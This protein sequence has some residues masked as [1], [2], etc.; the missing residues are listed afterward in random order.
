MKFKEIVV[1]LSSPEC[2]SDFI[3]RTAEKITEIR[4]ETGGK[5]LEVQ[6][7]HLRGLQE[8]MEA[9]RW[10]FVHDFGKYCSIGAK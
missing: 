7:D 2:D 4:K 1:D 8:D 10:F 6:L 3:I 9:L 5:S